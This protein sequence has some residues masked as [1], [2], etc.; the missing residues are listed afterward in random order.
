MNIRSLTILS[1]ISAS[2]LGGCVVAPDYV[3]PQIDHQSHLL[4]HAPF[5]KHPDGAGFSG[6]SVVLG[7]ERPVVEGNGAR[8]FIEIGEGYA[9]EKLDNRHEVFTAHAGFII[10]LHH[11]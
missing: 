8:A 7:W 9:I 2:S 3:K 4:D 6:A 11:D 5:T 10:P 1:I